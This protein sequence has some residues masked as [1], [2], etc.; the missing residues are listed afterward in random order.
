MEKKYSVKYENGKLVSVEVD[1]VSYANPDDIPDDEDRLRMQML[2]EEDVDDLEKEF[3]EMAEPVG[4]PFPF[5]QIIFGVFLGVSVLMLVIAAIAGVGAA[6][7]LSREVSAPGTI[8]EMVSRKSSDGQEYFYPLVEITEADGS[9]RT[10]TVG[11]GSWPPAHEAGE[12]VTVLYDPQHPLDARLKSFGSNLGMYT[13]TIITGILGVA[14]VLATF[15]VRWIFKTVP[16]MPEL[17][18]E[19]KKK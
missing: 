2:M 4:K 11:E 15:F 1:G 17:P 14:F 9:R 6:R 7:R 5:N 8:V 16:D 10:V 3:Q 18:D 12:A 19:K 13:V